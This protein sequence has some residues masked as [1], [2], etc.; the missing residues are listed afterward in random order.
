MTY[1]RKEQ[2]LITNQS[3]SSHLLCLIHLFCVSSPAS[4]PTPRSLTTVVCSESEAPQLLPRGGK[5]RGYL[6][7]SASLEL[8]E[9]P[10]VL[11]KLSYPDHTHCHLST[12][13]FP[14]CPLVLSNCCLDFPPGRKDVRSDKWRSYLKM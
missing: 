4:P 8:L 1:R 5:L 9:S 7:C 14:L 3:S 10:P 11:Q 13:H 6:P 2:I 12:E